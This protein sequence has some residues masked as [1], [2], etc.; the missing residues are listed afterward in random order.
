MAKSGLV[1]LGIPPD[2]TKRSAY[3]R[4]TADDDA[5]LSVEH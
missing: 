5:P 2:G 1:A 3:G 4:P